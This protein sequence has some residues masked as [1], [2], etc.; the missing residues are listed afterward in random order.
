LLLST[1]ATIVVGLA[2]AGCTDAMNA[3]QSSD[4]SSCVSSQGYWK[5]HDPWPVAT[6][7]SGGTIRGV[8]GRGP[9]ANAC[10]TNSL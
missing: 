1:L 3:E 9:S 8:V 10:A 7:V 4:L 5:N 2:I 6:L